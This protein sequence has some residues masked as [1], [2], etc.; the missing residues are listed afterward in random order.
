MSNFYLGEINVFGFNFAP[1]GWAQCN[2]Q[3]LP[4]AQNS[5]LFSLLG[6]TF[7]GN[8]TSNFG[9]PDM[10]SRVPVDF[11]NTTSLGEMSGLETVTL[12]TTEMPMHSHT[13][14]ATNTQANSAGDAAHIFGLGMGGSP[15]AA[16]NTY[17]S[18][19]TPNTALNP[20]AVSLAG[21]S[22]PHNNIQPI[23]CVNF[24]IATTGIYPSRN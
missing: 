1:R 7:G 13:F 23:L 24:C 18:G 11:G 20:Q 12:L 8:G 22:Q 3:I 14:G 2:G 21:G 4:I 10:R 6:T 15:P 5:A 17:I 9:L 19:T 16:T